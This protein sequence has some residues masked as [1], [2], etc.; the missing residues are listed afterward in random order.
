MKYQPIGER[1]VVRVTISDQ[2]TGG[3][4]LVGKSKIK[5]QVAE[6]LAVGSGHLDDQGDFVPLTVKVGDK[7]C[8]PKHTG[9]KLH[10][11]IWIIKE[12]E[13]LGVVS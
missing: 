11:D 9:N 5:E 8:F 6:V 13:C 7:V 1:I 2:T 4:H 3:I 12:S 10:D